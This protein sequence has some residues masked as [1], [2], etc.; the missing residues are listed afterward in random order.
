M[1]FPFDGQIQPVYVHCAFT[2]IVVVIRILRMG[3]APRI[4]LDDLWKSDSDEG[5]FAKPLKRAA[6]LYLRYAFSFVLLVLTTGAVVGGDFR[7]LYNKDGDLLQAR[8][9]KVEDG[10]VDLVRKK[11]GRK[12]TVPLEKFDDATRKLLESG[13]IFTTDEHGDPTDK[14]LYPRTR[15]E[16]D[17]ALKEIR[18]AA[19]AQSSFSEEEQKACAALNSYRFLCGLPHE[20][21]LDRALC[22]GALTAA[23]GCAKIGKLSHS[24]NVEASK[25]NLHQ[26]GNLPASIHSY[27]HDDGPRNREDRGHRAWCLSPRLGKFGVAECGSFS[28]MWTMDTSGPK[29]SYTDG[30]FAYPSPGFFPVKYLNPQTAWSVYFPESTLA[31]KEEIEIKVYRLKKALGK[32]P[33]SGETPPDSVKIEINYVSVSRRVTPCVNF[34]PAAEVKAGKRYWVSVKAGKAKAGFLVEFVK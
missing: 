1:E 4:G 23:E 21:A 17:G 6:R 18:I 3:E 10:K 12:F 8:V 20:V 30:F 11:D 5:A 22:R 26:L 33:K 32:A 25:C 19:E 27:M 9:L 16:I 34:E 13:E 15:Y 29:P 24:V 28:A 7:D 31:A 2:S 14:K